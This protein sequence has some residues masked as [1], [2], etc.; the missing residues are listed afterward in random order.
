MKILV[1]EDEMLIA[2]KISMLLTNLGYE[3]TGI[4]PRG[5]EALP[6]ITENKP[7]I[8]LLDINLKGKIDGIQTAAAIQQTT[9][10]PIIYLTAN[11]DDATFNRAK[12]TRPAAFIEKPFKQHN[13]QRALELT[14]SR[15]GKNIETDDAGKINEENHASI[16]SDRIFVRNRDRM[17]KIMV[18]DILYMEADRNYSH[19]FTGAKQF[20]LTVTLKTMEEELSMQHF[21]RVHRSFIINLIHVR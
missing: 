1:V 17:V 19:I 7:D 21:L 18:T 9:D 20:T 12:S 4:L 15:M 8:L 3:V 6:H 5:E 11:S 2:A 16:L 10:I 14:I 13:L